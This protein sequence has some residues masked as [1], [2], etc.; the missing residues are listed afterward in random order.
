MEIIFPRNLG[1]ISSTFF[2]FFL[3]LF[4]EPCFF[5]RKFVESSLSY[6]RPSE[7]SQRSASLG[8]CVHPTRGAI[9]G[10]FKFG[11]FSSLSSLKASYQAMSSVFSVHSVIL[12]SLIIV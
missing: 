9:I 11:H 5:P 6:A 3:K 10:A 2:S 12:P 1:S 7:S 4:K 8:H